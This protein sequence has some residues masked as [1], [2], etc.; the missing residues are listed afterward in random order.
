MERNINQLKLPIDLT[1]TIPETDPVF[2]LV[3]I[4]E[5]LDYSSL[6]KEYVRIWRKYHPAT[7]FEIIVLGYMNR[8]YSS[9]EI[10]Y[11]C[12]TDTRFIWLLDGEEAPDHSTIA[13]F[14]NERLTPA[15]TDLFYQLMEKLIELGE[16]S[17]TNV[18]ID[19]TKIEAYANKYTFV[20]AKN[21]S[22]NLANL[23]EKIEAEVP[24]IALRYCLNP[25]LSLVEL[26]TALEEMV[27]L[28]GI[29][30][31][32]GIGHR[33]TQIQKDIERL[34]EY[35]ERINGYYDSLKVLR[36]RNSYSKTDHDATFMRM[37]EDHMLNGQLKPAYNVQIA[38][39]S[40]YIVGTALFPRPGDQNTLIPFLERMERNTHRIIENVVAD[41]GYAS[42]ENYTY[43]EC[44]GQN[45]YIKPQF[46]E[47][48]KT[49]A[50]K[51]NPFSIHNMEYHDDENCYVCPAKKKLIHVR[52]TIEKSSN[53]YESVKSIYEC[54]DCANCKYRGN[55]F[56]S[57]RDKR[58]I[59]VSRD[60]LRLNEKATELIT[61]D[62]GNVLR[63]NRSI[64][65]EGAFGII[66]EDF[67]FRR[68]LT[69][70][71]RK[72]ETQF[73][74]LAFAFN[75]QKLNN[76]ILNKRFG[77]HLFNNMVS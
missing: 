33:K 30:F 18:F 73:L 2:K 68:F 63:F 50:F 41:A 7:L 54:K 49:K 32:H 15:I 24:Q 12:K 51:N 77:Q 74:L 17:Y 60:Y 64:Q 29:S 40:E 66:K 39:E 52:D 4:C 70:G 13:R 6:V 55:C 1:L 36:G 76:R 34:N 69:R 42:E 16:I 20:W 59:R 5:S 67:G 58:T 21:I 71:K 9:R 25:E 8:M 14:Q 22:K 26:K 28:Q 65:V 44:K 46:Y 27:K 3:E 11:A 35:Y 62:F 38:V 56:N 45:A 53:G 19:G 61:S 10:E 37:K 43:L 47:Q 23:E 75:I 72:T 31:A 57:Q 48:S